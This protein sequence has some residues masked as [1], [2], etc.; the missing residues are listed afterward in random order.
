MDYKKAGVDIEAGYKAVSL[1]KEHIAST[2]RPEVLTD[3]GGFSGAFSMKKFV[4][5]EEP[6]LVSGTDG[7][8]TNLKLHVPVVNRCFSW[9]ILHVVKMN[10]KKLRKL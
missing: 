10:R 6:T 1:M 9:I 2:M 8:G 7:V 3:I 4:G 5:M